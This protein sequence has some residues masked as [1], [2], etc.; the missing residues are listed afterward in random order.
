MITR[1]ALVGC[2]SI[3]SKH[4]EAIARIDSAAIAAVCD[5]DANTA[6]TMG[7]KLNVPWFTDPAAMSEAVAF[8]VFSILTPS[9]DHARQV[10]ELARFRRHFVVEKPMALRIQD[11]DKMI[12]ACDTLGSKI[13]VVKQNRY[14]PPV[15]ALKAAL[16]SGRLGKPVMGT[17]RLRWARHQAYYDARPWRGTWAQDG[18]VLTNQAAHHIDMLLWLMGEVESVMAMTA[19]RLANIEAED[20]GAAI[21]RFVSGAVGII[22]ATTA[23]RPRDLEGSL[24][25]LGEHG[26][27]EI[28]GFYMNEMKTWNFTS[29]T[30]EDA[31]VLRNCGNVPS[32]PAWNH[33]QYLRGV[34][35]H[36]RDGT[37]GMVDGLQG[38]KSLELIS[39]IYESAETGREVS[40]RF[41]P[42]NCRL[43]ATDD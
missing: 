3:A 22:E 31:D 43:G 27:V 14:N 28:G 42:R 13:F 17:V 21:L 38:R 41:R 15:V 4:V 5:H 11:A 24:S 32:I 34:I 8:E 39:A 23:T 6:K 9:G 7:S 10:L 19:T 35:D 20:T 29:P 1:F 33:E 26:T 16:D 30:P 18:G 36:L 37:S 25:I 2:G 40:L 12:A